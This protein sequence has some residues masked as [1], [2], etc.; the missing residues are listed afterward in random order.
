[1]FVSGDRDPYCPLADLTR[2]AGDMSEAARVE[3][4]AGADHF[5]MARED[6]VATAAL[7][8]LA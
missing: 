6:E 3:T 5:L 7:A 4:I 2:L 1:M 8:F